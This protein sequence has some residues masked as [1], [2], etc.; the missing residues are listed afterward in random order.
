V[1]EHIKSLDFL[2]GV[3]ALGVVLYHYS[4]L[5]L[6]TLNPNY[7][8]HIL[9]YGEYGVQ[10]FFVISGFII[11]YSMTKSNYTLTDFWKNLYRRYVRLAPPAYIAMLFSILIYFSAIIILKR[12]IDGISWPGMSI[13][14][15]VGNLTFTAPLIQSS[16]Y[17]PVFW[18]LAIEFQFYI[19]IGLLLPL[20]L[21]KKYVLASIIGLAIIMIGHHRPESIDWFG[22][23]FGHASFFFLGILLFLQKEKIVKRTPFIISAILLITVCYY[24]NSLPKFMF[25]MIAFGAILSG[26]NIQFKSA[27][28]LGGISYSLYIIHWPFGILIESITK[29]IIQ[30]HEYPIGKIAMLLFYTIMAVLFAHFFNK[31]IEKPFLNYSKKIKNLQNYS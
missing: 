16:W 4:G 25:G 10:I 29:R 20:L 13:H 18:T 21:N 12:P 27:T 17:N 14:A 19:L 26:I 30:L 8:T 23:F 15:V 2:R 1:K 6:P 11:P 7:L 28:Y 5:L 3:A 9:S 24:Q 31:Y 22:W